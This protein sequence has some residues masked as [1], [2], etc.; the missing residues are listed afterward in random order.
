ML[1]ALVS[2]AGLGVWRGATV[3][4]HQCRH[5]SPHANRILASHS[6]LVTFGREMPRLSRMTSILHATVSSGAACAT[7]L[8]KSAGA[9]FQ[10]SDVHL[11]ATRALANQVPVFIGS[12]LL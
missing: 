1:E 11:N 7:F 2:R 9:E 8:P 3:K 6:K 12:E 10:P 5:S 4:V